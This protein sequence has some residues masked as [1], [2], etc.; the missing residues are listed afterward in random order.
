VTVTVTGTNDAPELAIGA[1]IDS[2]D[3]GGSLTY[4]VTTPPAEG[5]ASITGTTLAFAP[6]EDFQDLAQGE[7]RDV[8]I[9]V[10][11]TDARGETAEADVTVTV[12]GTN[13]AP[14]ISLGTFTP[15]P[16]GDTGVLSNETFDPATILTASDVDNGETPQ[17]V[18]NSLSIEAAEDS[19]TNITA[20]FSIGALAATV[21]TANYD[22]LGAGETG[23]F[24]LSFD[25]ASGA[26]VSTRTAVI[27]IT[28]ENDAPVASDVTASANEDGP[29]ITIDTIV[30]DPDAGDTR[31]FSFDTF[32]TS[33]TVTDLGNG[34]FTYDPGGVFESLAEGV[35]T[36]DTF[37]YTVTDA[38]GESS[39]ATITV[40][41]TGQNDAPVAEDLLV[42]G[43]N[44]GPITGTVVGFDPDAGETPTF[45]L[46]ALAPQNGTV[47]VNPDGSFS[48]TPDEGFAGFDSFEVTASDGSLTDSATVTLAVNQPGSQAAQDR[49]LSI[50]IDA[51][52]VEGRPAGTVNVTRSSIEATPVNLVFALDGSGSFAGEF[53]DQIAAV[54]TALATL[55]EDFS[56]PGA[57][58]VDVQIIVFST[59]ATSYG[60]NGVDDPANG[61]VPFDLVG[62]A[63]A[64]QDTLD[65]ITFP[66]GGT[67]W[68][69]AINDAREFFDQENS[70]G[71]DEVDI[72]YFITDGQPSGFDSEW[73]N[74]IR[75]IRDAHDPQIFT[76]GIGGGFNPARLE[77]TFTIDGVDYRFDSDGDARVVNAA[78]DLIAEIQQTG[79]F[80]AELVSFSLEFASDGTDHGVIATGID[81]DGT[82]FT[83]P[84]AS[85]DGIEDL[86]GQD[87]DFVATAVFDL[88]GDVGTTND[89]VTIVEAARISAPD[90]AVS[91][92]GSDRADLMLGGA[93]DD[94]LE[95]GDGND[96]L[97]GGGGNDSLLGGA[98]DDLI[99]L[100]GPAGTVLADGGTGRDT[101][102]F[103]MGGDLT[104]DV[105]PTL[106][107]T[108]IEAL[109]MTNGQANALSL[110]L[111]DIEGL[112][113]ERDTDLEALLGVALAD[114]DSATVYGDVGDT[115]NLSNPEGDIVQNPPGTGPVSDGNGNSFD[116]YQFFDGSNT[117]LATL[118]VDDDVSVVVA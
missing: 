63:D 42:A 102:K 40:T 66:G 84:L 88:D 61:F 39:S 45:T 35:T 65:N 55:A 117:L 113:S 79:L 36:F 30:S 28:G 32:E 108:D 80:A 37:S 21:D 78:S 67:D 29:A 112:S 33:G 77:Q 54:K 9:R 109:D 96:L 105:L 1:D 70:A 8:T 10:S 57:P 81:T 74:A 59:G 41:V 48:Y 97:I 116:I 72:L 17:I 68:D 3:D 86:L 38:A 15:V 99:V 71:N 2:D 13:D 19:D 69:E 5:S 4:T 114:P 107:I 93:A 75:A 51:E 62:D 7:T 82:G 27:E 49:G 52:S 89:Q 104:N 58:Q 76:F 101:L 98:G 44:D 23:R 91:P 118:A 90:E 92:A 60:R 12:T 46:G 115:L 73:Q 31:S 111:A 22:F 18:A 14:E 56:G 110:T 85:V 43:D 26:D 6:G 24:V 47:T 11:A 94:T 20:P 95:G 106:T 87:N 50:S 34:Q 16:E 64:I 53:A 100:N 103:G 83:L 25:V